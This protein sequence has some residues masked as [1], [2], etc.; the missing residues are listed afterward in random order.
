MAIIQSITTTNIEWERDVKIYSLIQRTNSDNSEENKN[1]KN[2]KPGKKA[3]H[4]QSQLNT[5]ENDFLKNLI[6]WY[7]FGQCLIK[8][9]KILWKKSWGCFPAKQKSSLRE[10][11]I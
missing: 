8:A 10:R 1:Q 7:I 6:I 9:V 2:I 3:L 11:K 4:W 5:K